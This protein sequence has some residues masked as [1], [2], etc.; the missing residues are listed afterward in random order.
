MGR[1]H[2]MCKGREDALT[3]E[4]MGSTGVGKD[5][6]RD[7][8]AQQGRVMTGV[9]IGIIRFQRGEGVGVRETRSWGWRDCSRD[10][11]VGGMREGGG[12]VERCEGV[13]KNCGG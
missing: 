7:D 5:G 12:C 9:V 6:G 1:A 11:R 8:R 10:K 2:E 13:H 3:K 4:D